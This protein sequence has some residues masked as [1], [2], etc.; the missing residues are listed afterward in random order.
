MVSGIARRAGVFW[1]HMLSRNPEE[2]LSEFFEV[3]AKPEE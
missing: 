1:Q 3:I 2:S